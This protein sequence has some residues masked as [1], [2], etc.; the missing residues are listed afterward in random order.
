[1]TQPFV[2]PHFYM[3]YPAR[4]NPHL[5]EARAHSTVWAREM[6]MLEGSGVWEQSDLDAHDYGLLCAYTHPD[7][8][9]A[10]LSLITDWYVWVFFFDDHFLEVFKR[11]Q[12]RDGGKAYL[13]RLPL[14]MPLDLSTPVPEPQNPVEAGLADLW[15]RT[16]PAMSVDWRRRF[17]VATEHLLNESMWELSNINEGRISNPVEYIEMRR[18]VGGAP[19]SAGLVEY[20]TAEVP[21][22]VAESR[23]LRVLMETFSD[24]VHLRNDLFSY[25]REVE[26]EGELSNGVLVLETFFGCTTQE[27]AETVNDILTSRLHQFEHTALTEVPGLALVKGLTPDQVAAVAAYTQG[28]QDWQSGG[29]E[30]HLRSSRYMNEGA[31]EESRPF[32]L[33]GFGT[34]AA[35]IGALLAS[36]G[37]ER[38]RAYT[39]VP[40]QKVGPSLLPDFYMPFGLTLSPHLDG[41]RS[42]LVEWSHGMGILQEGVWDEDKLAAADL[43]LCAAGIHPDATSDALDLSSAWLAWGTYGDDYYPLVFGHRRD[44]AAAH[45]CTERLSACM[46]VEGDAFPVPVNGMER[47]LIDLWRRTTVGMTPDQRRTFRAA[48]D[49][50]TESWVWELVN[51]TQNRIPDPVD[52]LEMRR[53]TFGSDLTASLCRIGHGRAVPPEVYRS[54]PVRS[55]ENAA[56]DYGMLINDVFSYQKEIEYEGEIHN[57]ILVVQNF[58]GCDYPTALGVIHDLMTQRMQQFEHVAAHEFPV[59]YEDFKLTEEARATMDG[60]VDELRNWLAGILNWHRQVPRYQADHLARRSHGFLPDHSSALSIR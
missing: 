3:P 53:A 39:H 34:S 32:A 6:G 35:N 52:Y 12:D 55:L 24:G 56:F 50:M 40:Y 18:K 48:V 23:P 59:M 22:S 41:A 15:A 21:A 17:A 44:L 1:M 33:S 51:Q 42:R 31:L 4:L 8:D 7:C 19:W 47:G 36:A 11:S 9:G 57:G 10:A 28:L 30:W 26:D 14:F 25:Q 60:Y 49:K 54:G 29:H 58:F 45:L 46:P 38:L 5:D 20:A 27:A 16:V 43:P 2:L 37:A 13:D